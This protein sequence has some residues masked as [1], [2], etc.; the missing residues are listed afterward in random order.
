VGQIIPVCPVRP[1]Q[2]NPDHHLVQKNTEY[3]IS[4]SHRRPTT[5]NAPSLN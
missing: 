3:E 4:A 1:T 2:R 5:T